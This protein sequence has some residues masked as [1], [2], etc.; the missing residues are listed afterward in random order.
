MELLPMR[1][2]ILVAVAGAA[3]TLAGCSKSEQAE[4]D[5]NVDEAASDVSRSAA[6]VGGKVADAAQDVAD[7]PAVEKAGESL[8]E[9]ARD[10]GTVLK[11]AGK[12][13]VS[14]ARDG[15]AQAEGKDHEADHDTKR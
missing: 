7:S 6:E 14:G 1:K 12:G 10:T 11:E 2:L 4:A 9:A 13:A 15:I 8:K 3:L 5:R